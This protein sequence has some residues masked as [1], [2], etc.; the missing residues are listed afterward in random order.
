VRAGA[1]GVSVPYQLPNGGGKRPFALLSGPEGL[2]LDAEGK[3]HWKP[4]K[5]EQLAASK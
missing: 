3:V 5:A 1:G 4:A 2:K